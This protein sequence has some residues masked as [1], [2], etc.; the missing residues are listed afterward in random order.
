[1]TEALVSIPFVELCE[2]EGIEREQVVAVVE[3]GIVEPIGQT[4]EGQWLFETRSIVWIKKALRLHIDLD[5]D[6]VAVAMVIE[7]LQQKAKLEQENER[8]S[9][10]LQ[11]FV[12]NGQTQVNNN[13]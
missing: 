5:I 10:L 12:G 1:M 7:L 3:Y 2:I 9:Q 8:V 6:W 11:R 13:D 4:D